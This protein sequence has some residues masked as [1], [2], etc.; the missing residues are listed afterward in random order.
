MRYP[1]TQISK[2][3]LGLSKIP[4]KTNNSRTS[5]QQQATS[6]Q[7]PVNQQQ[8][9]SNQQQATRWKPD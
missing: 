3:M 6:N 4:R 1:M 2:K 7:Q 8:A 5:N 9:T